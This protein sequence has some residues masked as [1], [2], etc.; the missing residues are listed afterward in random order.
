MYF[1]AFQ[2]NFDCK[3]KL[4]PQFM[5]VIPGFAEKLLHL[6][7]AFG[8][9]V[10]ENQ[11]GE[12]FISGK[13]FQVA[14]VKRKIISLYEKFKKVIE[15]SCCEEINK[16]DSKALS[17]MT[18]LVQGNQCS[19]GE[20]I[21]NSFSYILQVNLVLG[22]YVLGSIYNEMFCTTQV[23]E[24][25]GENVNVKFMSSKEAIDAYVPKFKGKLEKLQKKYG[26]HTL[27]SGFPVEYNNLLN[28]ILQSK[29]HP[30]ITISIENGRKI[31]Y[32]VELTCINDMKEYANRYM[33]MVV[34][35]INFQ[36][37]QA[38]VPR[39]EER[40]II[41]QS[42]LKELGTDKNDDKKPNQDRRNPREERSQSETGKCM[43]I[44]VGSPSHLRYLKSGHK[45]FIDSLCTS[46]VSH[47]FHEDEGEIYFEGTNKADVLALVAKLKELYFKETLVTKEIS[48]CS[49]KN[50]TTTDITSKALI[51]HNEG[52]LNTDMTGPKDV[53]ERL[54][55]MTARAGSSNA[56]VIPLQRKQHHNAEKGSSDCTVEWRNRDKR[57]V[58]H[59]SLQ[60]DEVKQVHAVLPAANV[61]LHL[62]SNVTVEVGQ[63][64]ITTLRVDAIVSAANSHMT[65]VKGKRDFYLYRM[66]SL[67]KINF[68]V[69]GISQKYIILT[70]KKLLKIHAYF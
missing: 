30:Q 35:K 67:S 43:A 29:Y 12:H 20:K 31:M 18:S 14:I 63:G 48:C 70:E 3:V 62:A 22:I 6:G 45:N 54:E 65:H 24:M 16:K 49:S 23:E 51:L 69:S 34:S 52:P 41:L 39:T 15:V 40:K 21:P 53:V 47:Q 61:Y 56:P 7:T 58:S 50:Q 44:F 25:D 2:N 11:N 42:A 27:I 5:Q 10:S 66:C 68:V 57:L 9:T 32:A 8:I 36:L 46:E 1:F 37:C 28:D 26:T 60:M 13:W 64:D 19:F 55:S 4:K 38:I 59:G 33:K 17:M